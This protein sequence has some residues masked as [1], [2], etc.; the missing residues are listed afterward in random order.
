MTLQEDCGYTVDHT[1][2][3]VS[4]GDLLTFDLAEYPSG[5]II[6]DAVFVEIDGTI[7]GETGVTFIVELV[8]PEDRQFLTVRD[9]VFFIVAPED[10]EGWL[11]LRE[12]HLECRGTNQ[13]SVRYP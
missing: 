8:D 4:V 10:A 11:R 3:Q 12:R 9:G 2:A 1:L 5:Y 6:G 13:T 7:L